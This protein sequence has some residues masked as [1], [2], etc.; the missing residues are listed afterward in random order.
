MYYFS[1]ILLLSHVTLF[2]LLAAQGPFKNPSVILNTWDLFWLELRGESSTTD[3]GGGMVGAIL[4]SL[5]Y[6]LFDATGTEI[7]AFVAIIVGMILLTGKSFSD[8]L[9]SIVGTFASFFAKTKE[10]VK[11]D[12]KKW[13]EKRK[14]K[15]KKTEK[16]Q[17]Q[18]EKHEPIIQ[19]TSDEENLDPID[20]NEPIISNFAEK[21]N[22]MMML[23]EHWK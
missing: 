10:S 1:A 18:V 12:L 2:S 8:L 20:T 6:L 21:I 11:A 22:G 7:V 9:H 23:K 16:Q 13:H 19:A 15:E 14:N 5:L 4:F 17:P 3:L